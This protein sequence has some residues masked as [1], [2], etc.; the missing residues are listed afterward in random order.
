MCFTWIVFLNVMI[1]TEL[2]S[3]QNYH[4]EVYHG[5]Y[6]PLDDHLLTFF[7]LQICIEPLLYPIHCLQ[8]WGYDSE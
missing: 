6:V 3:K 7:F 4:T 2:S 8:H 1:A 5:S